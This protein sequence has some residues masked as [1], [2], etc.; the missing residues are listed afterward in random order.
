MGKVSAVFAGSAGAAGAA[1]R[2]RAGRPQQGQPG[3]SDGGRD[4]ADDG[5]AGQWS[6][7]ALIP[8]IAAATSA[9]KQPSGHHREAVVTAYPGGREALEDA[10]T[11]HRGPA[12]TV[13]RA[14][15]R[16]GQYG[17]RRQQCDHRGGPG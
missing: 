17:Y 11:D 2:G 9:S 12:L 16:P 13:A 8:W 10:G 7:A 14:Q 4:R 15:A 6:T 5:K 1:D 3:G